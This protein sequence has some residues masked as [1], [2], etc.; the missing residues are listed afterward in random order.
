MARTIGEQIADYFSNIKRFLSESEIRFLS[1]VIDQRLSGEFRSLSW[2]FDG[3]GE[4]SA[5]SSWLP[6]D[7]EDHPEYKIEVMDDGSFCPSATDPE[8]KS[9]RDPCKKCFDTLALAKAFCSRREAELT[10]QPQPDHFD[11]DAGCDSNAGA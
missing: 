7:A 11:S 6:E 8:L 3:S 4:W 5:K 9:H 2:T 1:R 10:H